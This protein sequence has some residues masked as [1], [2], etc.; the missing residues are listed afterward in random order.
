MKVSMLIFSGPILNLI[1]KGNSCYL[2]LFIDLSVTSVVLV[3]SSVVMLLRS[4]TK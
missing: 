2:L 3:G 1:F 4:S